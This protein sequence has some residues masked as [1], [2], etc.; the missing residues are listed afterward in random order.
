MKRSVLMVTAGFCLF[1]ACGGPTGTVSREEA[2][3]ICSRVLREQLTANEDVQ[4]ACL[5]LMDV[6]SGEV[7]AAVDMIA[8]QGGIRIDSLNQ[9]F[10]RMSEP[11]PVFETATLAALLSDGCVRSLEDP[12]AI[13][14]G[15]VKGTVIRDDSII[16]YARNCRKDS[17]SVLEG[18]IH[19]FRYVF[20]SLAVNNYGI[21]GSKS[22]QAGLE[23]TERFLDT[24]EGY[25]AGVADC[26]APNIPTPS[27]RYWTDTD[28]GSIAYGYSLE[29]AP[30]HILSFYN[31]LANKG[32]GAAGRI[33][34]ESVTDTL[35]RAL[36]MYARAAFET[37]NDAIAGKAGNSFIPFPNHQ[38]E[39]AEGRHSIQRTFAGFFPAEDPQYSFVCVACYRPGNAF[40]PTM[41]L[42]AE[43]MLSLMDFFVDL[44]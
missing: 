38:Y 30:L 21:A 32:N 6:R 34:A 12:V 36:R 27:T 10:V 22:R 44:R 40:F 15:V 41:D 20:S 5:M 33:C 37:P 16:A 4:E 9:A 35:A 26:P 2:T 25:F 1:S 18:F 29:L 3:E 7:L 28:L 19:S 43:V 31:A 23:K 8:E 17:L 39:D 14:S 24:I 11:G 42:P 13:G